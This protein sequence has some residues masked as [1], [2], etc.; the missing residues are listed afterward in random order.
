[1]DKVKQILNIFFLSFIHII[2]IIF[3]T[4]F[5]GIL[6]GAFGLV[7]LVISLSIVLF[8]GYCVVSKIDKETINEN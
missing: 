8:I 4:L 7:G 1:M 5:V 2:F 6:T 3:C